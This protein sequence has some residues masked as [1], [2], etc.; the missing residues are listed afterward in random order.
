MPKGR[1]IYTSEEVEWLKKNLNNDSPLD[2][3]ADEFNSLFPQHKVNRCCLGKWMQKNGVKHKR[4]STTRMPSRNPIGTVISDKDGKKCRVKTDHGYVSA[5]SYFKKFYGIPDE[6]CIIHLNG[7][8][9]DFQKD[10]I[11]AVTKDI[12]S[13]VMW[14]CWIFNDI[15]LTKTAILC[16]ELI[17]L[18]PELSHNENQF[19]GM[20]KIV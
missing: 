11:Q 19:L 3:I 12:Y 5:N 10:H 9:T 14:R 8:Y 13:A 17:L 4:V 6:L 2:V 18:L 1:W 7:D 16:A 15:E 20:K